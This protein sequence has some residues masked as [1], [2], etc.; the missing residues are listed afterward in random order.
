MAYVPVKTL[1]AG[2]SLRGVHKLRK[3]EAVGFPLA[4][5]R[6]RLALPYRGLGACLN[7][8]GYR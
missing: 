5:S 4:L 7:V 2:E 1:E 3:P 6:L 8:H